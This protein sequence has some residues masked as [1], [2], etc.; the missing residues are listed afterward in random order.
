MEHSSPCELYCDGENTA[1][2]H[3]VGWWPDAY[4]CAS[5]KELWIERCADNPNCVSHSS[6]HVIS[7]P[8]ELSKTAGRR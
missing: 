3:Q 7:W 2:W 4:A 1:T 6:W 8:C 5:C